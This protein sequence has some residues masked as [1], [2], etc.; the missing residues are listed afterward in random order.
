MKEVEPLTQNGNRDV[1]GQGPRTI[2]QAGCLLTCIAMCANFFSATS[3]RRWTVSSLNRKLQEKNL[4]AG[5]GLIVDRALKF[6]GLSGWRGPFEKDKVIQALAEGKLVIVG[7][8]Y[9]PGRSSGQSDADH[10][11]V[12]TKYNDHKTFE[13]IDPATGLVVTFD[14]DRVVHHAS[15][16]ILWRACEALIVSSL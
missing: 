16:T 13:A 4:F 1:L 6:L 12:F 10:F 11:V 2:A 7:V 3:W 5:S 8:D 15:K 14:D 9:K